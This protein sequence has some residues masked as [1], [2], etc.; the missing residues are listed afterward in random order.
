MFML[1]PWGSVLLRGDAVRA[2][3]SSDRRAVRA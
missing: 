2:S 1:A 3:K